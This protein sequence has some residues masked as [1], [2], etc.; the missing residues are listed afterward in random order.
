MSRF[1][2]LFQIG[3]NVTIGKNCVIGSGARVRE[4]IILDGAE[5]A[6]SFAGPVY[7]LEEHC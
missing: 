3:P 6:V 4:S 2:R 7:P 5:I 1:V